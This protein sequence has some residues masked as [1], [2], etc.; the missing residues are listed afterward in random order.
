MGI[1]MYADDLSVYLDF[2]G[3][4]RSENKQNVCNVL[5]SMK[6]FEE[7]SGLKINLGKTNLTVFGKQI[8]KP[9]FVDE[10]KIKW[11]VEFK[12]LGIYFDSTLS[13]M[14]VNYDIALDAVRSEINSWKYR[15]LTIYGKVTVMKNLCIPKIN[16]IV[17]VVPNPSIAH[18]K[19]LESEL[20]FFITDG[21]PSVVDEKTRGMA[22]R[23]G[24]FGIPNVNTFWKAIRMSWLRRLIA[25]EATWA[26]LHRFD[27]SPFSFDPCKSNFE[28]L[29]NAKTKVTN[30]FWREVYGSLLECRLNVLLNHPQEYKYIPINGE[31]SITSNRVSIKQEWSLCLTLNSIIDEKGN[32]VGIDKVRSSR[33][34]FDYEYNA[35]KGVTEDFLDV[36]SGGKLGANSR[37]GDNIRHMNVTYN[38]YGRLVTKRKKGCNFFYSLLNAHAKSDGWTKCSLKMEHEAECEGLIWDCDVFLI[39][40]LVKQVNKTP[41]LNRLKQFFLRLL[42]NNLFF[43]KTKYAPSPTCVICGKHPE[44]GTPALMVCEV[45]ISLVDRLSH[46]LSEANLLSQGNLIECF[47]Y[48]FYMFNSV[49]N[50]S[51]VIL[52]DFMYKA[53]FTPEKYVASGF[54][55]YLY[56]KLMW[57][58]LLAPNLKLGC[59]SLAN[60]LLNNNVVQHYNS[61]IKYDYFQPLTE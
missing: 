60:A 53:R 2:K 20:K 9:T 44:K 14:H 18:L 1:D 35:L 37:H 59:V 61:D 52:W 13:K 23:D 3:K 17:A 25:S 40:E 6:K 8:E 41:Y 33:K 58:Q 28:S 39:T 7:W 43:G 15:F 26:K 46:F 50:L 47:L 12:I 4:N 24:G 30:L 38:I 21:N 48:K 5:L 11:C 57:I 49:E 19:S 27:V 22:V 29:T 42:I 54:F 36:Y 55:N 45:T 31:P 10:L 16:H 56:H 32:L 51:L 34:P